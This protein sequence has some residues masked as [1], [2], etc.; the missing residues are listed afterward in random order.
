[1]AIGRVRTRRAFDAL[2]EQGA[3]ARHGAV[4]VT[5]VPGTEG[6]C[7]AY[8]VGRATGSAVTRNRV[9][10]RLRAAI[11]ELAPASGT[12]LVGAGPK[13]VDLPYQQLRDQL[14]AAIAQVTTGRAA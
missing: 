12:Y 9:R 5:Y 11:A 6:V 7:A 4:S 2:R 13:A 8:A 3:R 1:M 14:G 10:R